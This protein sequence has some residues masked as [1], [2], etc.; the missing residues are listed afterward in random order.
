MRR[1]QN[2][3]DELRGIVTYELAD[4]R[5]IALDEK[6]VRLYGAAKLLREYG[7]GKELPTKRLPVMQGGEMVGTMAPDFDPDFINSRSR[8]FYDP[9]PGDF[10]L[11]DGRWVADPS[12]GAGDLACVPGFNPA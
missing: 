2:F 3:E 8:I 10:R 11:V 9:R 5:R 12:L 1:L 6:A 4:G 7:L